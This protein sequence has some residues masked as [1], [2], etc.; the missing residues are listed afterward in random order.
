M[1]FESLPIGTVKAA[2]SNCEV[3]GRRF[4]LVKEV[5]YEQIWNDFKVSWNKWKG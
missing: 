1:K 5:L 2:T 3:K 4:K